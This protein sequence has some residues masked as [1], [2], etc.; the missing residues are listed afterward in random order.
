[1]RIVLVGE[2]R[3]LFSNLVL[4]EARPSFEPFVVIES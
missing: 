1:M 2:L 4:G 3:R